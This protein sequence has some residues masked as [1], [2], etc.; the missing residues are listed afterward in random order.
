MVL[1]CHKDIAKPRGLD[2]FTQGRARIGAEP[3]HIGN[4]GFLLEKIFFKTIG[5]CFYCSFYCFFENF[6][7]VKCLLG[8]KSRFGG[9]PPAPPVAESQNQCICLAVETGNSAQ[10]AME[11]EYESQEEPDVDSMA[12]EPD[13]EPRDFPL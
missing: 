3:R 4:P 2:R 5:Y 12:V 6:R 8:G 9:H 7:M 10:N 1:P 11:L 13:L